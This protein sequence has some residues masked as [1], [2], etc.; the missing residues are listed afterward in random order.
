MVCEEGNRFPA[1]L[2]AGLSWQVWKGQ[3]KAGTGF[4][5][6]ANEVIRPEIRVNSWR[7]H[8]AKATSGQAEADRALANTG[9]M[10]EGIFFAY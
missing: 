10:T 2:L 4:L 1:S 8:V 9:Y 6:P 5:S 7:L 3:G